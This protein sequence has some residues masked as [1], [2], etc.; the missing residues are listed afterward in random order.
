MK[1]FN[2]FFVKT[3]MVLGLVFVAGCSKDD[4]NGGSNVPD[5]E[6]TVTVTM[7]NRGDN[8]AHAGPGGRPLYISG[9][10]IMIG[11]TAANN[12]YSFYYDM[13][14]NQIANIGKVNGLG[15]IK[16]IPNSGFVSQTS[17]EPGCGYV[18]KGYNGTYARLYVVDWT[19]NTSG[20]IIGAKVK[21]Q[22]P[23]NP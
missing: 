22:Y 13:Q 10:D 7:E 12:F 21:Y 20:G 6:G 1:K 16:R 3:L 23:W 17:V 8:Y 2:L 18:I 15:A 19:T 5:P 11:M 14:G 9:N 4:D